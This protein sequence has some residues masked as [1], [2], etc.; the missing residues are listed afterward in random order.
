[1]SPAWV[2]ALAALWVVIAVLAAILLGW[3]IELRDRQV[4]SDDTKAPPGGG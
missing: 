3:A 4:P 1:M 2:A